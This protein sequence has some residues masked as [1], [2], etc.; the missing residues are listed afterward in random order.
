V[1]ASDPNSGLARSAGAWGVHGQVHAQY[2]IQCNVTV[3][4][5]EA[6]DLGLVAVEYDAALWKAC[7][8]LRIEMRAIANLAKST[9]DSLVRVVASANSGRPAQTLWLPQWLVDALLLPGRAP[10]ARPGTSYESMTTIWV[11][12]IRRAQGAPPEEL[13]AAHVL[14]ALGADLSLLD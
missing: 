4:E 11:L 14:M 12:A 5:R 13:D 7:D 1:I 9:D 10:K 2:G 8:I 6:R 3:A